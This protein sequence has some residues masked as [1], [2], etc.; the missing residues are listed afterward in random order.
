MNLEKYELISFRK[1]L[2]MLFRKGTLSNSSGASQN[3]EIVA[4]I[5]V[6]PGETVRTKIKE[7]AGECG[8]NLKVANLGP[9]Q[10]FC[11]T[12]SL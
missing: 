4:S 2:V 9:M 12:Y 5:T 1:E 10:I 3:H 11:L 7:G 6:T 8:L